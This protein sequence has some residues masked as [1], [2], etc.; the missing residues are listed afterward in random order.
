M[1][2]IRGATGCLAQLNTTTE[3]EKIE[4]LI[5]LAVVGFA[6][7]LWGVWRLS[8]LPAEKRLRDTHPHQ[9]EEYKGYFIR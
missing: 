4:A 5:L 1:N 8:Y 7:F 6:A 9:R 3:K 2:V